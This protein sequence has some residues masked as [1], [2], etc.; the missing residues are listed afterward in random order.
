MYGLLDISTSGMVAQRQ[1][2][3]VISHN[4]ANQGAVIDENGAVNPYKRRIAV[5]QVGR[6]ASSASSN[7]PRNFGVRMSKI[8]VDNAPPNLREHN[9]EH[10]LA[11]KSGPFKGWVA[12]TNI[13]S[14]VENLNAMEAMRAYEANVMAAETSKQMLTTALR[15]L[16]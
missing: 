13:S 5:F 14:V 1:R 10:P 16:G 6:Q 12:E 11:F 3:E 9:P 8:E 4:L 7:D 15:L 2:L